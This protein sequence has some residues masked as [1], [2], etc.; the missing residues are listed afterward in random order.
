LSHVEV[1]SVPHR[2][3]LTAETA[4]AFVTGTGMRSLLTPLTDDSVSIV[5]Q[6]LVA[7]LDL[8]NGWELVADSLIGTGRAPG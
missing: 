7:L 6:R 4:W 2:V 3:Q 8:R 5:R 1:R